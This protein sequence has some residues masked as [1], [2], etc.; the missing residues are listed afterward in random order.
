MEVS[1]HK[2]E[3]V[4]KDVRRYQPVLVIISIL[5]STELVAQAIKF[6]N[7]QLLKVVSATG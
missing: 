5:T 4:L 1:V 6:L 3:R 2:I 7:L